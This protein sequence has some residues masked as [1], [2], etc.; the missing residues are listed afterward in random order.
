MS[1]DDANS[2]RKLQDLSSHAAVPRNR[3]VTPS[4]NFVNGEPS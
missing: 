1:E 2:I 3:T 4:M